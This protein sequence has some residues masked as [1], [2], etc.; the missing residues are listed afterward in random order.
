[1]RQ[2]VLILLE[3]LALVDPARPAYHVVGYY[4]GLLQLVRRRLDEMALGP[5]LL[6]LGLLPPLLQLGVTFGAEELLVGGEE[7]LL[8]LRPVLLP[9]YLRPVP[10]EGVVLPPVHD[11]VQRRVQ[12]PRQH[13]LLVAGGAPH[14]LSVSLMWRIAV[15][16][17]FALLELRDY[18]EA[19]RIVE[20]LHPEEGAGELVGLRGGALLVEGL[21]AVVDLGQKLAGRVDIL[22]NDRVLE[23]LDGRVAGSLVVVVLLGHV[24]GVYLVGVAEEGVLLSLLGQVPVDRPLFLLVSYQLSRVPLRLVGVDILPARAAPPA[25]HQLHPLGRAN[26]SNG[27]IACVVVVDVGEALVEVGGLLSNSEGRGL[28]RVLRIQFLEEL[29]YVGLLAVQALQLLERP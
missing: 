24:L 11:F 25:G 2:V 29:L 28:A 9:H 4:A 10:L 16:Y 8:A 23:L 19:S 22:L 15:F 3:V 6:C 14:N 21:G 20:R 18:A 27:L 12:L 1:M 17:G 26:G 5:E 13:L 7:V